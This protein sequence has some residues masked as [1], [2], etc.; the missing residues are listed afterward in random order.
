MV[1][2]WLSTEAGEWGV[3]E[4]AMVMAQEMGV[5]HFGSLGHI[6][7]KT[8]SYKISSDHH[9]HTCRQERT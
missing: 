7:K 4:V 8:N 5:D 1:E 3:R 9:T 2:P 6:M